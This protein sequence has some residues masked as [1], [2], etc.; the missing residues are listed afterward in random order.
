MI[1]RRFFIVA[2]IG[3]CIASAGIGAGVTMLAKTGPPGPKGERGPVGPEG[4]E[5]VEGASDINYLESEVEELRGRVEEGEGL[6]DAVAQNESELG[7]LESEVSS[8]RSTTSEI[9]QELNL[10]C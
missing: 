7:Y 10:F 8:L 4:P 3:V 2:L 1:S 5:G 6:E 9:C